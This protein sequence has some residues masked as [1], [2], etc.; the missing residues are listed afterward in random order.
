MGYVS[1]V[2]VREIINKTIPIALY[3]LNFKT[4]LDTNPADKNP[5][6]INIEE[7]IE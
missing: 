5:P 2:N 1:I 4:I 7:A 6:T 3:F